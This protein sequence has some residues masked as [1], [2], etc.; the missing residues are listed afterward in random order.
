MV[1]ETK[2]KQANWQTIFSHFLKNRNEK[3]VS[4]QRLPELRARAAAQKNET[5]LMIPK[6][7]ETIK[8]RNIQFSINTTNL[9]CSIVTQSWCSTSVLLGFNATPR[10]IILLRRRRIILLRNVL[11]LRQVNSIPIRNKR[12]LPRT[13]SVG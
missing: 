10:R 6:F 11:E 9:V 12:G 3:S 1:Q 5:M 2:D 13:R 8:R 7:L 4:S